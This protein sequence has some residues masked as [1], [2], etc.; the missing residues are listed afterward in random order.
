MTIME[1]MEREHLG[2]MRD[3]AKP[4]QDETLLRAMIDALPEAIFVIDAEAHVVAANPSARAVLP[5]LRLLEPLA[6]GLRAPD[7]LD[8]LAELEHEESHAAL[9]TAIKLVGPLAL[10][11]DRELRL[12]AFEGRWDELQPA[13]GPLESAYYATQAGLRQAWLLHA[14]RHADQFRR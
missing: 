13:F 11:S 10:E 14:V 2:V 5:S 6:R 4:W 8:A 7:V 1:R 12:N 3:G 9:R